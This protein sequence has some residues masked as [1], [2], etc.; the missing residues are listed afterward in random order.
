MRRIF[1]SARYCVPLILL[2]ILIAISYSNIF[3][4]TARAATTTYFPSSSNIVTGSLVSGDMTSL[5]N[6]DSNYYIVRSAGSTTATVPYNP[7][8][9]NLLGGTSSVSGA[10]TDLSSNNGVYMTFRS[11]ASQTSTTSLSRAVIGYRSN[12]GAS[13][14]SSPK[15][16]SWDGS[17][18]DGAESELSSSGSPVRG[19]RAAYSPLMS[20]YHEKIIV[21]LSDDGY[22]DTYVW[23]GSSWSVTNNIG[24]VGTTANAYRPFDI[25]YE[26]T[27]GRALLAY[28]RGTTTNEI[29]Y[30]IWNG[31]GW[32][33]ENLLDLAY[34]TGVVYWIALASKP[35]TGSNQIAMIYIDANIN[36][37]GYEWTGSTWSL[38]TATAVWDSTAAVA[39]KES[40]AVAYEQ[41]SGKCMFIWAD[42]TSTDFYYRTWDGATL[43]GPTLLNIGTAAGVGNWLRLKANP[44]SNE[45]LFLCVDAGSALNTAYWSGTAWTVHPKQDSPIDTNAQRCADFAWEPTGSKGLLVWGTNAGKIAYK[46]FTAPN[47]WTAKK[48]P[49]MGANRHPWVQLR[50]NPRNVAEDV[51][52]L[53]A[54]LEDNVFD[55]G[56][57]KWDGT[58]FT[59]IGANTISSDTTVTT[60]ECFDLKFQIF[61]D[62]TQFTSEVE[63]TGSSNTYTWT[64]LVGTVDSAWTAA[65]VTV[66]I[67][68]YNYNTASYPTS[69]NGYISYT[70][71][72]TP[73]T[74]ETKTQTITTNPQ[75]FRDGSGSWKIK[76][77]GVKA[78]STQFDLKADWVEYKAYFSEYTVSTEFLFSGITSPLEVLVFTVVSQYDVGSVSGT[79]QVWNY[80]SNQYATSGGAYLSYVSSATPSTDETRSLTITTN[81]SNYISTGNAKIKT[82]GVTTTGTQCLQKTN[83]IKLDVIKPTTTTTTITT[84]TTT[85]TPTT[86]TTTQTSNTTTTT[87]T[88]TTATQTTSITVP[89]TTTTTTT[90]PTTITTTTTTTT[91]TTS[92]TTSTTTTSSTTTTTSP[93][94]TTTTTTATTPTTTTTTT[95]TTTTITQ[96][97]TTTATTPSTTTT[98]ETTTSY[99][100]TAFTSTASTTTTTTA[101]TTVPT[102]TT[103]LS[104]ATVTS[105][106]VQEHVRVETR[107]TII[108]VMGLE[109]ITETVVQITS[110][111]VTVSMTLTSLMTTTQ[112]VTS[113]TSVSMMSTMTTTETTVITTTETYRPGIFSRCIIASAAY[114]SDLAPEVQFLRAFRDQFVESTFAGRC[115]MRVFN[116]FYYSFSPVVAAVIQQN[117]FLSQ[118]TRVLLYP[119]VVA[120][121][122]ASTIFYA[123]G[124]TPEFAVV[125]S[126]IFAAT[127]IGLLYV[128]PTA[129]VKIVIKQVRRRNYFRDPRMTKPRR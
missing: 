107:T 37:H 73:N 31:T 6:V 114:G 21:T 68:L 102:T 45:L 84:T 122:L 118:V 75:N 42:A 2:S 1:W 24:F 97:T 67:Q 124:F 129:V 48:S 121:R 83:Q 56:A 90:S 93:T 35:T 112:T 34:T 20:R 105:V 95:P 127:L 94:T 80:T 62:A 25:A 65:N 41:S 74:D 87:S 98:T 52:I 88:T 126:G 108:T 46:E 113:Q 120:L 55:I 30:R 115:F 70:S 99:T 22:L 32:S 76:I 8:A 40:V 54:V 16:R 7:T 111:T 109:R 15:T 106:S 44:S 64:Q 23:T 104:T 86:T 123:L 29:G 43:T 3:V 91:Q 26:H 110:T 13:T 10:L 60:Y 28:S 14:L 53:G 39:T 59:V 81:P 79:I 128:T 116:A 71:S 12:T 18:W 92:T 61:G 33:T 9:Y 19:V 58:T 85:T 4:N 69:G 5:V 100:T 125:I 50:T 89:T 57:I 119:L 101:T 117:P 78:T 36:V 17:A 38:M 66:T 63:F 27:T 103:T 96:T 11:Y 51:K 82:T 72:A 47:T 49:A 77:K